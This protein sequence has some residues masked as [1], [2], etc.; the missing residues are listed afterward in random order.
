[1]LSIQL[2]TWKH[3]RL[4]FFPF[5]K[6]PHLRSNW[7]CGILYRDDFKRRIMHRWNGLQLFCIVN[8]KEL[9]KYLV[10]FSNEL[11]GIWETAHLLASH[12]RFYTFNYLYILLHFAIN[13]SHFNNNTS[14]NVYNIM[15]ITTSIKHWNGKSRRILNTDVDTGLKRQNS[16]FP[17]TLSLKLKKCNLDKILLQGITESLWM[18]K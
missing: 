17:S 2:S 1:M 5:F 12:Q 11:L 15:T 8:D 18:F 10:H 6:A 4:L 7:M 16:P 9:Y 13:Y 14:A 3:L